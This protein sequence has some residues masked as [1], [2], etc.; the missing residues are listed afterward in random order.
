MVPGRVGELSS[1]DVP[2]TASEDTYIGS[3]LKFC[4]KT[5]EN[6]GQQAVDACEKE[7]GEV[8]FLRVLNEQPK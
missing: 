5:V 1:K 7:I 3:R 8:A 6:F 2:A 4:S